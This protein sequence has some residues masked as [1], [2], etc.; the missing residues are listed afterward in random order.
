MASALGLGACTT[1][2]GTPATTPPTTEPPATTSTVAVTPTVLATSTTLDRV[3][4]IQAIFE[5][6]E[7]RRLQ[8]I[9]DQ[10]EEAFRSVFANEEYEERSVPGMQM[11]TVID[12]DAIVFT[13]VE[14]FV[15][16]EN[17]IAVVKYQFT[18]V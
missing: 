3:A 15:D 14:V 1:V 12:P 11:V 13:V 7:R 18:P 4:E 2:G 8:A 10:D 5:D 6:L 9:L 16:E 17:C